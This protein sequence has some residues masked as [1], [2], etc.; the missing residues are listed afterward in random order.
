MTEKVQVHG[1]ANSNDDNKQL[2]LFAALMKSLQSNEPTKRVKRIK[3]CSK[4]TSTIMNNPK[5]HTYLKMGKNLSVE[6]QLNS[7]HFLICQRDLDLLQHHDKEIHIFAKSLLYKLTYID[8]RFE[9]PV[10]MA[11]EQS[12]TWS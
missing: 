12:T 3:L 6:S 2:S 4:I 7:V 10:S 1:T 5:F 9:Q 11:N 8:A